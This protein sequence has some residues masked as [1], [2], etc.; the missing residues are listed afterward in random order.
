MTEQKRRRNWGGYAAAIPFFLLVIF[1]LIAPL[2]NMVRESFISP[3]SG[4]VTL[5][6]YLSV[7]SKP[8]YLASI[9]NSLYLTFIS[10]VVGLILSFIAAMAAAQATKNMSSKFLSILNMVANFAGLPLAF[11]FIILVGKS[12]VLIEILDQFHIPLLD[13]FNIYSSQGLL[14]VFTYFQIP[15]GTLVLLPSFQS[16][17]KEWKESAALMKASPLQFWWHIGIP[18]LLPS[19]ADTFSMLFANALTA[20]ATPYM[21]IS[22]NYPLLPIK[23]TSMFTGEMAQQQELGS[24]LSI[25]MML[26]MLIVIFLCNMVKKIFYKGGNS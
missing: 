6:N 24:A 20:Y 2:S 7:L 14:L 4:A 25:T 15:L 23:I 9:R 8:I 5:E 1:F 10:T 18:V 13:D 12:G 26:I 11:A 3:E 22:T 21:I 16:I 17:R 19:L